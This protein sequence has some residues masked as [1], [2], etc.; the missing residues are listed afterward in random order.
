MTTIVSIM[1]ILGRFAGDL[2]MS[3]LGWASSLLFGRVPR[4]HQV[5]L[6]LMMAV[7]FLWIVAGLALI[8]PSIA[9]WVLT[10]TPHPPF[11]NLNWLGRALILCVI[12]LPLAVGA[13][14]YLVPADGERAGGGSAVLE[15]LRGYL[16]TPLIGGLLIFM[17]GVGI[18]RKL[19]SWRHH[20]VDTHVPIVAAPG[21]YDELVD[22]LQRGLAAAA[23][24]VEAHD[25]PRVLTLPA[26]LLTRVAGPSVRKLRPDRLIELCGQDVRVGVYPYDIAISSTKADRTRLR[27][28]VLTALASSAAHLTT[29]AEAQVVED[30]IR[31]LDQSATGTAPTETDLG[32]AI[33]AIDRQMLAL[34]VS[35]EE[36]DVLYRRRLELE[37]TC[38]RHGPPRAP[39]RRPQAA[40]DLADWRDPVPEPGWV[41]VS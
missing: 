24:T 15:V 1:G 30:R 13:A 20:W 27:A 12:V 28:A 14:G 37:C 6:V 5:F 38:L 25:A 32:R 19:R 35:A 17:A 36:W 22:G 40:T 34:E 8:L 29:S 3:S 7:S 41:P 10:A 39:S 33:E 16:L 31:R 11:V 4:S 18:A 23:T 21:R 9:A 2:L 26:W